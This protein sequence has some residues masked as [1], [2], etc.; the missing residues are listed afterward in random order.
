PWNRPNIL[1][2]SCISHFPPYTESMSIALIIGSMK[3]PHWTRSYEASRSDR[4][5]TLEAQ[6][7]ALLSAAG[8][9]AGQ[10]AHEPDDSPAPITLRCA[11]LPPPASRT[12][13]P[14]QPFSSVRAENGAPKAAWL[15]PSELKLSLARECA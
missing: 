10:A 12:N 1:P 3:R 6:S 9:N 11:P 13:R 14:R 7:R 15:Q 2:S 4:T 5:A 8:A